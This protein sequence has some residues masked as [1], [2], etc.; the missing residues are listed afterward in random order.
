MLLAKCTNC[1]H[2]F[3]C[4]GEGERNC[5]G[6]CRVLGGKWESL[7]TI[8]TSVVVVVVVVVLLFEF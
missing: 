5:T 3:L 2:C 8:V 7:Y 1:C 4:V 6:A